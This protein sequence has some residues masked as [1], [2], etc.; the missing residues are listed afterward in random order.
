[1]SRSEYYW[2]ERQ[3]RTLEKLADKTA[4]EINKQLGKQYKNAMKRVIKDFEDTYAH[5]LAAVKKGVEPTPADLYKLDRYWQMQAQ[6]KKEL[7]ALG[8]KT[9]AILSKAFE[10]EWQE[11]YGAI[12]LPS[13]AAFSTI[14]PD[15]AKAIVNSPWCPDG[16]NYSDRIWDNVNKLADTLNEELVNCVTTGKKQGYLTQILQQ[17]FNTTYYN[18]RRLVYT[19]TVAIQTE[20]AAQ[21]YKDYGIEEYSFKTSP[22]E[23]RCSECKELDGKRFKFSEKQT[24]KNAPPIHPNCKCQILPTFSDAAVEE[25]LA[26]LY[27][28]TQAKKEIAAK[29]RKRRE[30]KRKL[31]AEVVK[32]RREGNLTAITTKREK[33][34]RLEAEIVELQAE[35][36]K[37]KK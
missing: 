12:A 7:Q 9:A 31:E 35:L 37:L 16:K 32:H 3:A 8:D 19:E 27:E 11:V 23:G 14:A 10:K 5:Y 20:A 22:S 18:A 15:K 29:L 17:R 24:G 4:E 33:I 1:M 34:R 2:A 13:D 28:E 26:A 30:Q 36:D 21:R 6:L 25:K